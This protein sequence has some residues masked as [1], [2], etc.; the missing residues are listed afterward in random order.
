LVQTAVD[1]DGDGLAEIVGFDPT[2]S[3]VCAIDPGA[4]AAASCLHVNDTTAD[5][6]VTILAGANLTMNPGLDI[7]IAQANGGETFFSLVED[8]SYTPGSLTAAMTRGLGVVGPAHGRTVVVTSPGRPRS[9]LVFG[10]DGAITCVLG[11]C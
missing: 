4:S 2:S 8:Y 5:T 10:T 7:L 11:P 9:V 1:L 6:E 3:L